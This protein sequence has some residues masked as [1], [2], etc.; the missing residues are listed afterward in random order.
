M[1]I[2]HIANFYGPKSGGI[3]TT[4]HDL[5]RR[6]EIAGHEFIFVVPGINLAQ[7]NTVYGKALYLSS[8]EIPFTGGY[9]VFKSRKE[10]KQA[11]I[12]AKPDRI[13]CSDRFTLLFLGPWA[14]KRGIKT[15]VFSHETLTGLCAKFL[16]ASRFFERF[17]D[18]HNS[19]LSRAFDHVV[20]TTRFAAREFEKLSTPNLRLIPLGVDSEV[21]TPKRRSSNLRKSLLQNSKYLLV[22][23]GRLSPEKD[24]HLSIAA[25]KV[26]RER[27]LI[28]A[29]LIIIGGGPLM[30]KLQRDSRGLPVTFTGYIANPK[31]IA[32]ILACADVSIAPGPL[33]T[34]CLS[35]L[36]S[37]SCGTPVV[38]NSRS[39]VRELLDENG[40]KRCGATA[41][42]ESEFA[43][44]IHAILTSSTMRSAARKRALEFSWDKTIQQLMALHDVPSREK[45]VA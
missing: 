30:E 29:H 27:F 18:W 23:C 32:D 11:I 25:L 5:G 17:A 42:N 7:T 41:S 31:K 44:R 21:F 26:L 19:R 40:V 6:Y 33:E 16:P 37:L 1:K 14:R 22:H 15:L 12:M 13:E 9:R 10:I 2:L 36:E 28:D 38:A 45:L 24:P 35:A 43:T 20:A 34:F 4:I 39:A 3:K 8:R